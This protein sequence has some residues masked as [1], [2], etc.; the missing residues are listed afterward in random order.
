MTPVASPNKTW[1]GSI[2]GILTACIGGVLA[3]QLILKEAL[4]WKAI[5]FAFLIHLAA[6]VSD[7]VESLFKRAAGVKDSSNMLPGH[8]GFM[9]RIDSMIL[10]VPLFYYLLKFIGMG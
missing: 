6:Q 3:Q 9:D 10:A 4:L 7:P 5:V 8:G 1:E 2:G